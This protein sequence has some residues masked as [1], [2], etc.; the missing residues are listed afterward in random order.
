MSEKGYRN[1]TREIEANLDT[2]LA[3]EERNK[4][5]VFEH[6]FINR[7]IPLLQ[8]P[9]DESCYREYLT[10]VKDPTLA[11]RVVSNE[12]EPKVLFEVPPLQPSTITTTTVSGSTAS[13][14]NLIDYVAVQRTRTTED[15]EPII[16]E[17][18]NKIS[19]SPNTQRDTYVEIGLIL[20]RYGKSFLTNDSDVSEG[21]VKIEPDH[22]TDDIF[23]DEYED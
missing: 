20:A 13:V 7:V 21:L 19:I 18:L 11:L 22:P 23:T 17:F 4:P 6:E 5:I 15:F 12:P 16:S 2:I 14:S 3:E 1:V 10:Y 8:R 9:F